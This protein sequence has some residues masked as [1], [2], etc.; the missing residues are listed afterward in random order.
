MAQTGIAA[1]LGVTS[2]PMRFVCLPP[3]C[4]SEEMQGQMGILAALAIVMNTEI[5]TFIYIAFSYL[6]CLQSL[7]VT[8]DGIP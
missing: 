4:G 7:L 5:S 3:A 6:Y 1:S 2:V 8:N